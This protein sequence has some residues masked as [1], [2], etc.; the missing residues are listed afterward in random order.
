MHMH[1]ESHFEASDTVRDIVIGMADG[2]TVPFALAAG[3]TGTAAATSKLV[4]IAG[5]AEIAAGSIAM[6]LGGYLAARTD[7]D[8]YESERARELHETIELPQKERD[9]VADVFDR[10]RIRLVKTTRRFS[11][12][13]GSSRRSEETVEARMDERVRRA[14]EESGAGLPGP[15]D[16]AGR[17]PL[18]ISLVRRRHVFPL[19]SVRA[20]DRGPGMGGHPLSLTEGFDCGGGQTD[21]EFL[22]QQLEGDAVIV[23]VHL[24]VIV[25]VDRRFE[26]F[27]IFI[28]FW[29]Q[30]QGVGPVHLLKDFPA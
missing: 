26:P 9:E 6:G 10:W 28:S 11:L 13:D 30:R 18:G 2:L 17:T 7:S 19:R 5:I 15:L 14:V 1:V 22:A 21:I 27:G 25:D 29:W 23:M 20:P 4:V 12:P 8:H 16:K 24:D 3:L